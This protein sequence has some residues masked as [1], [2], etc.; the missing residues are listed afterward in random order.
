M[1]FHIFTYR[2]K[3][4]LRDKDMLFWTLLFPIV[5]GTLF[6]FA[7][8]SL[9]SKTEAFE[10]CP[11]AVVDNDAYRAN[12]TFVQTLEA[13][14]TGDD[15]LLELT[16]A[17]QEKAEER[18]KAGTI[19]GYIT[20]G[21]T[22]GLTVKSSGLNQS[23]V[24]AFLDQYLQNEKTFASILQNNPAAAQQGLFDELG[25]SQSYITEITLSGA[26][27]DT[28][29]N[30]FYALLAMSCLYGNYWGLRNTTEVQADLSSM[31][32]RRSLAPSHKLL[33]VVGDGLAALVIHFCEMLIVLAYLIFVL[34]IN[35][36]NQFGY[37]MLTALVGSITGVA[38]GTFVGSVFKCREG[39]KTA[40]MTGITMFCSFLSG[41]MYG[42]M[43]DVIAHNAPVLNYINPAALITD[44]FYCLYIYNSHT[45]FFLNIA[46][47]CGIS[48]LFVLGSYLTVRR[49]KYDSI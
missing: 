17:T 1:F 8:G 47:L 29:L 4:L 49:Q 28:M 6:Y 24:K 25:N 33:A 12:K 44:A 40:I 11:I 48:L 22:I 31:G 38:F 27:P 42:S 26:V 18:L 7:F 9:T 30:Y 20:V 39:L 2:L 37:V 14:S 10:P 19:D 43:K 16:T 5:L 3:C 41:L 45:R 35:F 21:E 13:V 15:P 32:A 34:K 36:G 46:I 23:I